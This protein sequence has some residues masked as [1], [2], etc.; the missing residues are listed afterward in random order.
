MIRRLVLENF[1]SHKYSE[2]N[3]DQG[4]NVIIGP[5]DSG[6]TAIIR[7]LRWLV[8]N[9]PL[10]DSFIRH[11]SK[12]C[13]VELEIDNH[14]LG[15]EKE[16]KNGKNVYFLDDTYFN[17]VKTETPE[18]ITLLLNID[19]INLQQQ[20]D[21][22]FLLDSSPG[23]VAQ[24]FNRVARLDMIDIGMKR[25]LQWTR[26]IQ[27]D[28]S[29]KENLIEEL[30]K[31]LRDYD[32]LP[33]LEGL[34]QS[35]ESMQNEIL[36]KKNQR[37]SIE[38]LKERLLQ[39]ENEIV[40]FANKTTLEEKVNNILLNITNKKQKYEEMSALTQQVKKLAEIEQ[41]LIKQTNLVKTEELVNTLLEK[42]NKKRELENQKSKLQKLFSDIIETEQKLKKQQ[43]KT[44]K[45][46]KNYHSL[47]PDIC[48][49]CGQKVRRR[50]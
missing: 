25:I 20:F 14:K 24:H 6:K 34:I 21:R 18:E 3:F 35:L 19:D 22:P 4:V 8:W 28:I 39:V 38:E 45:L 27:Q 2:L 13:K 12:E 15:R 48:P 46:E 7:A 17:A 50:S 5:S 41:Q 10:G 43:E 30:E 11:G 1:Q 42:I 44:N 49:L 26:R 31:Q 40:E 9:R 29:A 33:Y 23:E 47:F 36:D 32:Y 37:T 16:R